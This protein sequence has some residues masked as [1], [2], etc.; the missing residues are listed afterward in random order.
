MTKAFCIR[1][2][3]LTSQTVYWDKDGNRT[4]KKCAILRAKL[5]K[6]RKRNG[7]IKSDNTS[8]SITSATTG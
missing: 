8:V 5:T 4:C 7:A 3:A 1:G 2:H 6:E